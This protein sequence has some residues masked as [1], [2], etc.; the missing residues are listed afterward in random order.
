LPELPLALGES[1]RTRREMSWFLDEGLVQFV[2]P[3]LGRSGITETL[4][5]ANAGIAT[6]PHVSVAMG[7]QIAAAIHV[8]AAVSPICEFN[9]TVL[10][11][12]NRHSETPLVRSGAAY[13]V[14]TAAGLGVRPAYNHS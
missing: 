13:V 1:Y 10:T 3:D 12:A 5:I 11:M 14:P 9:P 4:R 6:V 7:P 8:A 2:Q